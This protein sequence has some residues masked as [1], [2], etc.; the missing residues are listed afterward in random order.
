[1]KQRRITVPLKASTSEDYR[2]CLDALICTI[3]DMNR[4]GL[5]GAPHEVIARAEERAAD[6]AHALFV[7]WIEPSHDWENGNE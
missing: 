5:W 2:Y 1:M 3:S 4:P 7:R 6:L